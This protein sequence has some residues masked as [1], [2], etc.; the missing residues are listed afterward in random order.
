MKKLK[1]KDFTFVC[2]IACL[3]LP[4]ISFSLPQ[5]ISISGEP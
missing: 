3:I 5:W 2:F 4:T 1:G